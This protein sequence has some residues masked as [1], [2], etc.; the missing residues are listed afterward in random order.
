MVAPFRR[1]RATMA[2]LLAAAAAAP[3]SAVEH[4]LR[5][6]ALLEAQAP[7][8]TKLRGLTPEAA[9]ATKRKAKR[10]PPPPLPL[11]VPAGSVVLTVGMMAYLFHAQFDRARRSAATY[12][13]DRADPS[14]Q[15]SM[16][17]CSLK[18]AGEFL[19]GVTFAFMI[20]ESYSIVS[21]LTSFNQAAWLSGL[22]I[23]SFWYGSVIGA[24]VAKMLIGSYTT[25]LWGAIAASLSI[26]LTGTLFEIGVTQPW[27]RQS[28]AARLVL[29]LGARFLMGIGKTVL[30]PLQRMMVVHVVPAEQQGSFSTQRNVA[31]ILSFGCGPLLKGLFELAWPESRVMDIILGALWVALAA[32]TALL[33]PRSSAAFEAA[34][35]LSNPNEAEAAAR[36]A[37]QMP[38]PEPSA[39]LADAGVSAPPLAPAT[40]RSLWL[41]CVAMAIERALLVSGMES[42]IALCLELEFGADVATVGI[43]VGISIVVGSP[44]SMAVD[45]VQRRGW[46]AAP[47]L[48]VTF[49]VVVLLASFLM[50]RGVGATLAPGHAA[51][52]LVLAATSIIYSSAYLANG[53]SEGL[54]YMHATSRCGFFS[55]ENYAIASDGFAAIGRGGGPTVTNLLMGMHD[56]LGRDKYSIGQVG[57][58]LLFLGTALSIRRLLRE[59]PGRTALIAPPEPSHE[60]GASTAGDAGKVA[61]QLGTTTTKPV[62][63]SMAAVREEVD[64]AS[65]EEPYV[66]DSLTHVAMLRSMLEGRLLTPETFLGLTGLLTKVVLV[67]AFLYRYFVGLDQA[68]KQQ[69]SWARSFSDPQLSLSDRCGLAAA[70]LV[71]PLFV[72]SRI[73]GSSEFK[74]NAVFRAT[75]RQ[76]WTSSDSVRSQLLCCFWLILHVLESYFVS[77]GVI[78]LNAAMVAFSADWNDVLGRVRTHDSPRSFPGSTVNRPLHRRSRC[79]CCCRSTTAFPWSSDASSSARPAI[80][81]R[82]ACSWAPP[83]EHVVRKS[84]AE[85]PSSCSSGRSSWCCS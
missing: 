78:F 29:V 9:P 58:A 46:L 38:S 40:K 25:M 11:A 68:H 15:L 45:L 13:G 3:P 74:D 33:L 37:S 22:A 27:G 24:G 8:V 23:G 60:I 28:P 52:W 80:G 83:C 65:G 41:L 61:S 31:N 21:D 56:G 48:L 2:F 44:T 10:S 76:F 64:V 14:W 71:V 81:P 6:A 30:D 70:L 42:A 16:S 82:R 20:P 19:G 50:F 4:A 63:I 84:S 5:E 59:Q 49:A 79:S 18:V 35:A 51:M 26:P 62:R 39:V 53:V 73:T 75:L 66:S 67:N 17:V 43:L 54:A 12:R 1:R 69:A 47:D 57:F 72:V 34:C 85:P 77:P 36:V 32:L 7:H 55:A